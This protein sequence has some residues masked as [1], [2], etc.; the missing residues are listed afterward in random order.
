MLDSAENHKDFF[1]AFA[2]PVYFTHQCFFYL[3]QIN[4]LKYFILKMQ[5]LSVSVNAAKRSLYH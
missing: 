1:P 3:I 4:Y 2:A 5:P